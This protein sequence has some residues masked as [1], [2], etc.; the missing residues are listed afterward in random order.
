MDMSP[1]SIP[2]GASFLPGVTATNGDEDRA[3]PSPVVAE[4]LEHLQRREDERARE[5]RVRALRSVVAYLR[6]MYD[7]GLSQQPGAT[8]SVYGGSAEAPGAGVRSRRPTVVDGGRMPSESS[9]GSIS[10]SASSHL[11]SV[12]SRMGLRS[13]GSAQTNSVASVD[14]N[15]SGD[16]Q[17][18]KYKDDKAKRARIMREIVEYALLIVGATECS[19]IRFLV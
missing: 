12:E 4:N 15:G 19:L 3:T 8:M 7:L 10:S 9:I 13:V 2:P 6:D 5:A 17:E 16:G 14:S 18:R 11:R 1:I